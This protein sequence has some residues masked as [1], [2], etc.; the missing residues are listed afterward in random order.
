[1]AGFPIER[2]REILAQ[3]KEGIEV[4]VDFVK[5]AEEAEEPKTEEQEPEYEKVGGEDELT[6]FDSKGK[7]NKRKRGGRDRDRDRRGGGGQQAG[8]GGQQGGAQR[9]GPARGPGNAGGGPSQPQQPQRK[10]L[11]GQHRTGF[12]GGRGRAGRK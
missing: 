11:S 4:D 9:A 2:V 8:S 5:L 10:L 1:M 6:R 7:G 12:G 3:N